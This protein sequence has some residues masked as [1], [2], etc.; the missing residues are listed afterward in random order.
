MVRILGLGVFFFLA[1]AA[2]LIVLRVLAGGPTELT[3][4]L[5]FVEADCPAETLATLTRR[6]GQV[7]ELQIGR[8]AG[9][10]EIS[11]PLVTL[12]DFAARHAEVVPDGHAL[13]M[14]WDATPGASQW[15]MH[16]VSSI[17]LELRRVESAEAT[18]NSVSLHLEREDRDALSAW[19]REHRGRRMA[20]IRGDTAY[21]VT[22]A[23]EDPEGMVGFLDQDPQAALR[24]LTGR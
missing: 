6:A 20:L 12:R 24:L 23:A 7:S 15:R 13:V 1:V 5:R 22:T 11:G 21:Y 4:P 18:S 9:R 3:V 19:V 17:G 16:C 2:V 14:Q 10:D 8:W